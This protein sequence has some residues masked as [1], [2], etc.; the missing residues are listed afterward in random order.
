MVDNKA[1]PF[2][3]LYTVYEKTKKKMKALLTYPKFYTQDL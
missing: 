2:S 1:T 3:V